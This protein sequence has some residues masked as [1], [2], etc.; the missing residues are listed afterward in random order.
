MRRWRKQNKKNYGLNGH[1]R[2]TRMHECV[3]YILFIVSFCL[4]RNLIAEKRKETKMKSWMCLAR[5]LRLACGAKYRK[6]PRALNCSIETIGFVWTT[7]LRV[8]QINHVQFI[9]NTSVNRHPCEC[10]P[11]VL[12]R[13]EC[14]TLQFNN[15]SLYI[16]LESLATAK[17][18][19][20]FYLPFFLALFL[21]SNQRKKSK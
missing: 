7:Y 20:Y 14:A 5:W 1:G 19:S 3:H 10:R 17:R 4:V 11:F 9:W 8:H 21:R 2:A 13:V 16:G 18:K 15:F 6:S 12:A